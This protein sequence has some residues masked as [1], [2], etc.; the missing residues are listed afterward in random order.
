VVCK[1]AREEGASNALL[2][3]TTIKNMALFSKLRL[4][5]LMLNG[6]HRRYIGFKKMI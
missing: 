4:A 1:H 6:K 3:K 2:K 5:R